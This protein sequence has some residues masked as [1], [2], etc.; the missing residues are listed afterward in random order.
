MLK[1]SNLLDFPKVMTC[2]LSNTLPSAIPPTRPS[3]RDSMVRGFLREEVDGEHPFV[4]KP[5]AFFL[6]FYGARPRLRLQNPMPLRTQAYF[7]SSRSQLRN[8]P[9]KDMINTPNSYDS[10]RLLKESPNLR[11]L[12]PH[13]KRDMEKV[14][15][16]HFCGTEKNGV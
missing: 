3:S 9:S 14:P 15:K 12:L 11:M 2:P 7:S 10:V 4:S 5:S 13:M 1:L 6:A 8:D 16:S